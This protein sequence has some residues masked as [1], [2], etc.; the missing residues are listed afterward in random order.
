VEVSG[1]FCST[2]GVLRE[3][4]ANAGDQL[5]PCPECGGLYSE[6]RVSATVVSRGSVSATY[7]VTGGNAA[8]NRLDELAAAVDDAATAT[9]SGRA[10]DAVRAV[11]RALEAIHELQ[12]CANPKKRATVE[13][14]NA[15]WTPAQ[16]EVWTGLLGARN[17]A[18]HF[19]ADV[20]DL[21]GG[22]STPGHVLRWAQSIP[23]VKVPAQGQAY[24]TRLAGQLVLP[25]LQAVVADVS[26]SM[27]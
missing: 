2:C 27:P 9:S 13:W 19:S 8:R 10:L 23:Q 5:P 1:P 3:P 22:T 16:K 6:W 4:S 21:H 24:A 14:S 11:K 18:H 12:D 20:V 15:A 26:A 17:A 25:V 7:A